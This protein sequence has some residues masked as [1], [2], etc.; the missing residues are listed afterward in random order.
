MVPVGGALVLSPSKACIK[1][2]SKSYPGRASISAILDLFMTLLSMGVHGWRRLLD[3]RARLLPLLVDGLAQVAQK[4]GLRVLACPEN[5]I[6]IALSLKGLLRGSTPGGQGAQ[7][8][9]VK[10]GIE[11]PSTSKAALS[12]FGS[13]LFRRGVSGTRV[14]RGDEKKT[15]AG[16]DFLGWGASHDDFQ[17]PYL[18]AACAMGLTEPKVFV[19]L[20]KL[21]RGLTD[22]KLKLKGS[23]D[24]ST[25]TSSIVQNQE[26][27][28]ESPVAQS[29]SQG[30]VEACQL[31]LSVL[32][33]AH[34]EKT[35]KT[36]G[37]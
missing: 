1:V 15:I 26:N 21:D 8:S 31:P 33:I 37:K 17:H 24:D 36:K 7:G 4:H 22:F 25:G 29:D 5:S 28:F 18:T 11:N 34:Y 14:V 2:L 30:S 10:S 3:E 19:F 6:S 13:M 32:Y 16:V 27:T 9:E 23:R 35:T 12:F 20:E